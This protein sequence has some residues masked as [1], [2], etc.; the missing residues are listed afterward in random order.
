MH[1][2]GSI[3]TTSFNIAGLDITFNHYTL[4]MTWIVIF[5][6]LIAFFL[7]KRKINKIPGRGQAL[8]ELIIDS[9]DGLVKESIGKNHRKYLP[10]IL[11]IFIFVLISNW[12]GIVPIIEEP[13]KDLNTPMGLGILVLFVTVYSG[14]RYNGFFGFIKE[15][16][17]PVW[18]LFPINIVGEIGKFLSLI[19]R[20]FGNIFG[21]SVIIW[22]A[23]TM[24]LK[25]WWTSW[26][27]LFL[28][29]AVYGFFGLFIG[30]IQAFVFA[31]L[32]MTYISITKN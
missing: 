25:S 2:V 8:L 5:V 21:G 3:D 26:I 29:P 31:I 1:E 28:G 14:I 17:E 13:T 27:L 18:F 23:F 10:F 9:F 6:I 16:F 32:S 4:I 24:F 11:T 7:L 30:A 15:F 22:V 12:I 19:F 20:L